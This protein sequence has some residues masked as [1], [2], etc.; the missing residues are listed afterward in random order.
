MPRRIVRDI[1]C[2]G[3]GV[4]VLWLPLRTSALAQVSDKPERFTALAVNLASSRSATSQVQLAVERWSSD[5]DRDR[6]MTTLVENGPNKLLA[7][8]QKLPRAGFI[9]SPN[10]A[11]YDVH[12]AR[13]Q[14]YGDGGEQVVLITD[15][16]VTFWEADDQA[17]SMDY[18]F[19]LVELHIGAD[20]KGE[21]KMSLATKITLDKDQ[22]SIRL[23]D[24]QAQPVLLQSVRRQSSR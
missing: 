21:G 3:A 16:Y 8:L 9:R 13:R 18:P 4:V 24:Y 19:T 1:A 14:P 6:L 12:Y 20:G 10:S 17:P 7:T 15:R 23:Q 5:A 11:G 22:K 2:V